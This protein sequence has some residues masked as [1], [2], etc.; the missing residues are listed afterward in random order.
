MRRHAPHLID[1]EVGNLLRRHERSGR[2]SP[3]EA[4][5]T[6]RAAHALV[7]HRYPQGPETRSRTLLAMP[8]RVPREDVSTD[9]L[10]GAAVTRRAGR[11]LTGP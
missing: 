7:E 6:L 9:L 10:N 11:P 1:A 5:T 3:F 8:R 4:Y 2:I